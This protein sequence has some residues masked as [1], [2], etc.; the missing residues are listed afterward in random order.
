MKLFNLLIASLA[1]VE[2]QRQRQQPLAPVPGPEEPVLGGYDLVEYHNLDA[3]QDG[4][5]ILHVLIRYATTTQAYTSFL[6]RCPG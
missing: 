1:V 5:F 6:R 2:A 4:K 3:L